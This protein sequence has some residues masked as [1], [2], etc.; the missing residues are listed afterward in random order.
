[1]NTNDTRTP[2]E[3]ILHRPWLIEKRVDGS[4]SC[5]VVG[6]V[7][8]IE[9][10]VKDFPGG[11]FWLV[12]LASAEKWLHAEE[13]SIFPIDAASHEQL[14]APL[15]S[16]IRR[17]LSQMPTLLVAES[18]LKKHTELYEPCL[19][20]LIQILDGAHSLR[21][22]W[23]A[24][25]LSVQ[26]NLLKNLPFTLRYRLDESFKDRCKGLPIFVV[27]SGPSLDVTLPLILNMKEKAITV[28]ADSALQA[29]QKLGA[30]PD[31]LVTLDAYKPL[32]ECAKE[33][34]QK[35]LLLASSDCHMSWLQFFPKSRIA[36]FDKGEKT[37]AWLHQRG[38]PPTPLT[39]RNN[40]GLTAL[41][42]AVV[43][44]GNP[45]ILLGM[46]LAE[47]NKSRYAELTD[48]HLGDTAFF[49]KHA[50]PGSYQAEVQS[51]FLLDWKETCELCKQLSAAITLFNLNDRGARIDGTQLL[52]PSKWQ[53]LQPN[54][55]R[56]AF[57]FSPKTLP[58]DR[59]LID[60]LFELSDILKALLSRWDEKA[61]Q[62][63]L[64]HDE[65]SVFLGSYTFSLMQRVSE[66][67]TF[68]L[69]DLDR[70]G[71]HLQSLRILLDNQAFLL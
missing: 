43:L 4:I 38:V 71:E 62:E 28:A 53:S 14:E 30:E 67:Q 2:L 63:L 55:R 18:I 69:P 10:I 24:Q 1:M 16:F 47:D 32:Q 49:Q 31:I 59:P 50:I 54:L 36:I 33:T 37:D 8:D 3:S 58:I 21:T 29:F 11:V 39:G 46:D 34:P 41:L 61:L 23:K 12:D 68:R 51:P 57:L 20:Q 17:N 13:P 5:I 27:G 7:E 45:I 40:A 19:S 26:R 70:I 6:A 25:A 44:G 64:E 42:T 22:G 9:A 56:G 60:A 15:V 52:H 48:R 35:T 66:A 65:L